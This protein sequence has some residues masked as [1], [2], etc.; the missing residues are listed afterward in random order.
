MDQLKALLI[1]HKWKFPNSSPSLE[2]EY[3]EDCRLFA[4]LFLFLDK[5]RH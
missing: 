2:D 3:H 4:M 5:I 1:L